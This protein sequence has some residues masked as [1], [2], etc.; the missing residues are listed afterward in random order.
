MPDS[1]N[2]KGSMSPVPK[3]AQNI[4]ESTPD[5]ITLA[6]VG[7]EIRRANQRIFWHPYVPIIMAHTQR[8]PALYIKRI[9]KP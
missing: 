7:G 9:G 3:K 8:R 6:D 4:F 1:R 5:R 2:I